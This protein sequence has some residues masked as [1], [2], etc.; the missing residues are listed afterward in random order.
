LRGEVYCAQTEFNHD[1]VDDEGRRRV[2]GPN[3]NVMVFRDDARK[4]WTS[5]QAAARQLE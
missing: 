2:D 3:A 4:E 5:S 1:S